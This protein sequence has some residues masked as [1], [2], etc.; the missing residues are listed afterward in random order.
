MIK[1]RFKIK[2][3]YKTKK[4]QGALYWKDK[5]QVLLTSQALSDD[6]ET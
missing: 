6:L 5:K 2:S 4:S 3:N 1:V